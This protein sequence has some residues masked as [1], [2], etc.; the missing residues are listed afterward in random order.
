MAQA[1]QPVAAEGGRD[2]QPTRKCLVAQAGQP[3]A[4]EGGRDAQPLLRTTN[5]MSGGTGRTACGC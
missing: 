1:G 2:A 5:L 4:A 3:V